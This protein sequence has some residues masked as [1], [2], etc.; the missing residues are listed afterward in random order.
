MDIFDGD[1]VADLAERTSQKLGFG[2]VQYVDLFLFKKADNDTYE[3]P[4]PDE[5]AALL[6]V[7]S[8]RL[9]EGKP[10]AILSLRA[11]GSSRALRARPQPPRPVS[12]T[13][14]DLRA[15]PNVSQLS[16]SPT[17][18]LYLP[19]TD[20]DVRGPSGQGR[21]VSKKRP[22]IA[23]VAACAHSFNLHSPRV[24]PS[25]GRA[26]PSRDQHGRAAAAAHGAAVAPRSREVA[27][28][29]QEIVALRDLG[30]CHGCDSSE[31]AAVG[32]LL[33]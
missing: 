32:D 7:E 12:G 8:N 4:T 14:L 27:E 2:A 17:I 11:T 21:S 1:T 28:R 29:P 20:V 15:S 31:S 3:A 18:H 22:L 24:G 13:C 26:P 9:G 16:H 33:L 6:R 25:R 23:R 30:R 19:M 5:I 10:L